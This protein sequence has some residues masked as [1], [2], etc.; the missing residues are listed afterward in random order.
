M[1]G[2][3]TEGL[4]DLE[5]FLSDAYGQWAAYELEKIQQ[6]LDGKQS[7]EIHDYT[8]RAI[9]VKIQNKEITEPEVKMTKEEKK[10]LRELIKAT[11]EYLAKLPGVEF[12]DDS[13][14]VKCNATE[15]DVTFNHKLGLGLNEYTA[16]IE[17]KYVKMKRM[18]RN[19]IREEDARESY[20][21]FMNEVEDE[22]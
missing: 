15:D 2:R 22:D 16:M 18:L 6:Q 10:K 1:N 9:G 19:F 14:Y 3:P 4:V 20:E 12:R 5:R 13:D 8:P 17:A 21:R 11:E 7:R